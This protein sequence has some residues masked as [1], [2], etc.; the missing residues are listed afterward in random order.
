MDKENFFAF[1]KSVGLGAVYA[2]GLAFFIMEMLKGKNI[3]NQGLLIPYFVISGFM[4]AVSLFGAD[5]GIGYLGLF[6]FAGGYIAIGVIA[7]VAS[8]VYKAPTYLFTIGSISPVYLLWY[9]ALG[10]G[11]SNVFVIG[12]LGIL[13]VSVSALI[14]IMLLEF[15]TVFGIIL[16]SLLTAITSFIVIKS[17]IQNGSILDI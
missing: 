12:F 17:R 2:F 14:L 3:P 4:M 10:K 8:I 11:N 13:I 1:I 16:S 9:F 5:D 6:I 7:V 15:S